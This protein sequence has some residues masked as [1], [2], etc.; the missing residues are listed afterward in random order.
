[1]AYTSDDIAEKVSDLLIDLL[2]QGTNRTLDHIPDIT[3]RAEKLKNLTTKGLLHSIDY[4]SYQ[5][6]LKKLKDSQGE[7]S[8]KELEALRK[9]F[10]LGIRSLGVADTDVKDFADI[11]EQKGVIFSKVKLSDKDYEMFNYPEEYTPEVLDA[12]KVLEAKRGLVTELPADLY[13]SHMAPEKITLMRNFDAA[14]LDLFRHFAREEGLLFSVIPD[15]KHEDRSYVVFAQDD[16]AKAEKAM[17]K[18][19][20]TLT[21]YHG[22]AMYEQ[23]KTRVKMR[24]SLLEAVRDP[25]KFL[26]V[27]S[28]SWPDNRIEIDDEGFA[29]FKGKNQI[30]KKTRDS[31]DF[32]DELFRQI[33]GISEPAVF[34]K[35]EFLQLDLADRNKLREESRSKSMSLFTE[36]YDEMIEMNKLAELQNLVASKII[37]NDDNDYTFGVGDAS[38]S[39]SEFAQTEYI[40]D[41]DEI[42]AKQAELDHYKSAALFRREFHELDDVDMAEKDIDYIIS[43]AELKRQARSMEDPNRLR[44]NV[45]ERNDLSKDMSAAEEPEI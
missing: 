35:E 3:R 29:V 18:V 42:D 6:E 7:I 30:V 13:I 27:L 43:Q 23:L 24:E 21:G 45:P 12:T 9:K 25:N 36:R 1:M 20:W 44:N 4:V 33:E 41:E 17:L 38:I 37:L 40:F 16:R 5:N 26:T 11:L 32:E 2:M 10:N 15:A 39:L 28:T 19:G 22:E 14:K 34:T 31:E 8:S